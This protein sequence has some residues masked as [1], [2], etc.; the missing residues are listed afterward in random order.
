MIIKID[1]HMKTIK[2][3]L[4][5]VEQKECQMVLENECYHLM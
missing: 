1:M 3:K 5:N 4:C 2:K